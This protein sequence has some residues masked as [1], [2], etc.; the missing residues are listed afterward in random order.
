MEEPSFL[1]DME[2]IQRAMCN[3]E[4]FQTIDCLEDFDDMEDHERCVNLN[5]LYVFEI[6][7]EEIQTLDVVGEEV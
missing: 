5:V 2:K 6:E 4:D 3:I 7:L 1:E